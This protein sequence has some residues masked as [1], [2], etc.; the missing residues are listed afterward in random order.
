M[1]LY[2]ERA[3]LFNKALCLS[4][5]GLKAT[6]RPARDFIRPGGH[7]SGTPALRQLILTVL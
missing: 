6:T 2:M 4:Q 1:V 5:R 3:I 7:W